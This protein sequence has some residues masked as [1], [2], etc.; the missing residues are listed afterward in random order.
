MD[1]VIT[2][3]ARSKMMKARTGEIALPKI[4]MMA[5]GNGGADSYGNALTPDEAQTSLN[6]ELLRKAI[7]GHEFLSDRKCRYTCTI[8]D[9]ELEG[10]SISELALVDDDGDLV[11]IKNFSPKVKEKDL[12]MT[13]HVDD[14]F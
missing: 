6:N 4:A 12:E 9:S 1:A 2:L 11:A 13:V 10:H 8:L 5:F 14:E 3:T 7:T